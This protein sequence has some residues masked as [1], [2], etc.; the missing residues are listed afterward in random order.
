[1]YTFSPETCC[2]ER[3]D[4]ELLGSGVSYGELNPIIHEG[5]LFSFDFTVAK[6]SPIT[7]WFQTMQILM[8]K[9]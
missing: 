4:C 8:I 6:V 9:N 3:Q 5:K 7:R 2:F 1:M